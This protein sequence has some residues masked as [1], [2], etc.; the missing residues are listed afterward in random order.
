MNVLCMIKDEPG[1]TLNEMIAEV[2]KSNQVT[3]VDI[4]KDKDY[5]KIVDLIAGSEKVISV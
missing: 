5:A 3:T 2:G 4:R 1:A